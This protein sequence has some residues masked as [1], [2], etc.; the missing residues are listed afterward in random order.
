MSPADL[1]LLVCA[2]VGAGLAGSIAGLASLVSYPALL[3]VG[4]GPV[5]ANV[6][7]TVGLVFASAGS[8]LGSR[9]ELRGQGAHVRTLAVAAVLGGSLGAALLLA[10]PSG[11]FERIAPWLIGGAS[12]TILLRPRVRTAAGAERTQH[13]SVAVVGGVFL[14]GIYGGYFGAAAGVVLLALLISLTHDTLARSNALKNAV[15]GIANATAALGFVVLAPVAWAAVAP[16]AVGLFAGGRLGPVVVRHANARVLRTLIGLAGLV[17]AV[18]LGA[19][20]Y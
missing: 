5:A 16:L 2:G 20:A 6:T 19:D 15:L 12:L 10:T 9:T 13:T 17:L 3:A 11:T 8:M 1:L 18:A 7:N 4:L 14:V